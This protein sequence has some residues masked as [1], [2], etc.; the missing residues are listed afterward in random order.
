[1]RVMTWLKSMMRV[2]LGEISMGVRCSRPATST[3]AKND[4]GLRKTNRRR[5]QG[6][7]RRGHNPAARGPCAAEHSSFSERP[8]GL[9][10]RCA[11]LFAVQ[12]SDPLMAPAPAPLRRP[13]GRMRLIYEL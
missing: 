1:M 12:F 6:I 8:N 3:N 4:G 13:A 11:L 5:C 7:G 9:K 10:S 2:L